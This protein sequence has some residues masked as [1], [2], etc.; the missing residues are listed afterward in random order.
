M[1]NLSLLIILSFVAIQTASSQMAKGQINKIHVNSKATAHNLFGDKANQEVAVYLPPSYQS[2]D[3]KRYPVL[4]FLPGYYDKVDSWITK[5]HFQGLR[6]KESMDSLIT[7]NII[8]E[9]IVVVPNSYTFLEGSFY[10]NS[11]VNGDY[12]T[13]YTEEL[14]N[15]IDGNYRTL[16]SNQSRAIA[17]HSMGGSGALFLS[18][19]HADLYSIGYGLCS[20]LFADNWLDECLL[21]TDTAQTRRF[22]ALEE[23]LS[24]LSREEAHAQY[25]QTMQGL[26]W[27]ERF[28]YAYGTAFASDK[29][30]KAPYI[31]FPYSLDGDS[32]ILDQDIL[33]LWEQ[34]FG[35]L[36]ERVDKYQD[37]LKS[38][39]A[40]VV[41]GGK[42]DYF[43]YIR[44]GN[45]YYSDLLDWKGIP[46]TYILH[47]GDH[48]SKVRQQLEKSILPL[49]S[50]LLE[51][52]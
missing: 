47:D 36:E 50:N 43:K 1:K 23:R 30:K 34:G 2:S 25:M 31:Q 8:K 40:Y 44:T 38:L 16:A 37:N 6:L 28:M 27:Y 32:L 26:E 42:D 20:G 12:E 4:Y 51:F 13:F 45:T 14:I 35:N 29:S 18:M 24:K 19:K 22:I 49:C 39:K 10:T 41:D 46:H 48:S 52:E 15:H 9:M 21:F 5:E 3:Q 11:S 17:G 33:E 7:A